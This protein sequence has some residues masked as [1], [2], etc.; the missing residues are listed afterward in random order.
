MNVISVQRACEILKEHGWSVSPPHIRAGLEA[1]VYPFG[2]AIPM[3]KQY[4][5]DIHENLLYKWIAERE[6]NESVQSNS[7]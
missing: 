5:Y 6:N 1:K 3:G 2:D 4:S 7:N